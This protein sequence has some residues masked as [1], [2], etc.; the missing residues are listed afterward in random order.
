[1]RLISETVSGDRVLSRYQLLSVIDR[2]AA[3]VAMNTVAR[4]DA[5]VPERFVLSTAS[6]DSSFAAA[7]TTTFAPD[8]SGAFAAQMFRSEVD[9]AFL[10]FT[11]WQALYAVGFVFADKE[12]R[13]VCP[14]GASP[15]KVL[16]VKKLVE[17]VF[18]RKIEQ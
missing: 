15:E 11:Y 12:V 9:A 8:E 2:R 17:Q 5:L 1:V 10:E 6:G 14:A 18:S 4:A 13:L 3:A 7:Y 16:Q